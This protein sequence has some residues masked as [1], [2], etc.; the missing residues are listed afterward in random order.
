MNPFL[1]Y[2]GETLLNGLLVYWVYHPGTRTPERINSFF[3]F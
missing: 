2:R 3:I 1:I